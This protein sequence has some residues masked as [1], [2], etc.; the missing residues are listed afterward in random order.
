MKSAPA[1][2]LGMVFLLGL[3]DYKRKGGYKNEDKSINGYLRVDFYDHD[4]TIP[5]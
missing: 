2:F 5:D 1:L 4:R 3:I